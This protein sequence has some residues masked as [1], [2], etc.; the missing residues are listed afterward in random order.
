MMKQSL[1]W[2]SALFL[3]YNAA[4]LIIEPPDRVT[5][6]QHQWQMNVFK[7]QEYLYDRLD[8]RYV[9]V[10]TSLT[11]RLPSPALPHGSFNLAMAGTSTLE[12]LEIIK[13]SD[14]SPEAVFI[15]SNFVL[16]KP[17]NSLTD[18]LFQPVLYSLRKWVPALRER[19]QPV[20]Y[21]PAVKVLFKR[22]VR[23]ISGIFATPEI[24]Q[25]RLQSKPDQSLKKRVSDRQANIDRNLKIQLDALDTLP[26]DEEAGALI[27]SLHAYVRYLQQKGVKIIFFE[28]PFHQ[29]LYGTRYNKWK[30]EKLERLFPSDQYPYIKY[31]LMHNYKTTDGV[32]LTKESAL[33]YCSYLSEQIDKILN[34]RSS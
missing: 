15:E 34:H 1:I 30:S 26:S 2:F 19:N 31:P 32:H 5:H 20:N 13:R 8:S 24:P 29:K 12:G 17:D 22:I 27:E 4:L 21:Y 10:G 33:L 23:K 25:N 11:F 3:L 7:A 14:T 16:R 9:F 28:V 18:G 6:A